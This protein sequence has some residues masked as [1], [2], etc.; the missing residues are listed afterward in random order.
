MASADT[1][2]WI[3]DALLRN[4]AAVAFIKIRDHEGA[5]EVLR[6]FARRTTDDAFRDRLI[7]AYLVYA[8]TTLRGRMGWR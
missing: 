6:H 2:D 4:G 3:P 1:L 5:K 8:D 7:G